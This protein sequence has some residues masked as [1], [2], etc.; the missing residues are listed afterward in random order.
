MKLLP[1]AVCA[2]ALLALGGCG[3]KALPDV[4]KANCFEPQDL[5]ANHD[6]NVTH[7][8]A[9]AFYTEEFKWFDQSNSGKIRLDDFVSTPEVKALI[10]TNKDGFASREEYVKYYGDHPCK[11]G[12]WR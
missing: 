10:D 11:C 5:D 3:D 8:E 1:M 7:E 4:S 2:A 12:Q 6:G 9:V